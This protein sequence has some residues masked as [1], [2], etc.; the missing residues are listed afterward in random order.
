MSARRWCYTLNNYTAEE[1]A[2]IELIPA[3]YHVYGR[4][5]GESGT[6][7]LQGYIMF[8]NAKSF[9]AV[10]SLIGQRAHLE[11]AR[12][13]SVQ[14]A[15]YCKKDGSFWEQGTCPKPKGEGEK[16]RWAT[17]RQLAKEGKFDDIDPDIHIRYIGNL[18]KI[19]ADAQGI[20]PAQDELDFHWYH[21]PTGSGKS[22]KARAENPDYYLKG[23]NKWWDGY[24]GQKCVII[25]EWGPMN[26]DLTHCLGSYL[27]MWCDHHCFQ[28]EF[29]GG[30]KMIRPPKIIITSNWSME[31]CFSNFPNILEPLKR[32]ITSHLILDFFAPR[33]APEPT[34]TQTQQV[35]SE[36]DPSLR[37]GLYRTFELPSPSPINFDE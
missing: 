23:I 25:E 27:K 3:V 32:R 36:G 35:D 34:L 8:A 26:S 11:K 1:C 15:E 5:V 22:T 17:A 18:K 29:K 2:A 14:A 6:P 37:S 24:T 28:A 33:R 16:E 13:D 9:S 30:M 19:F 21:G 4:E 7:H 12:G 20:P 31:E 10:K